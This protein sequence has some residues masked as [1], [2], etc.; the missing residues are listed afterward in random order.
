MRLVDLISPASQF[1]TLVK[2][3]LDEVITKHQDVLGIFHNFQ[4]NSQGQMLRPSLIYFTAGL[5][6]ENAECNLK[7]ITW[8]TCIELIHNASLLHDNVLDKQLERRGKDSFYKIFGDTP[9]ILFGNILYI[10]SFEKAFRS[11]DSEQLLALTNTARNMCIGELI[12]W[13][14]KD[15]QVTIKTYLKILHYKTGMLI[16]SSVE[17]TVKLCK[18]P[19]YAPNIKEI[20]YDLGVLYQLYDD[21]KDKDGKIPVSIIQ[22]LAKKKI[23]KLKNKLSFFSSKESLKYFTQLIH[24]FES[25]M[26]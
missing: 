23:L 9:S 11:L 16:Q 2:M 7:L 13:H 14:A 12:Q 5:L 22:R 21:F 4:K 18:H 17:Q 26:L 10:Y 1:Q 3:E 25:E 6:N 8:A 24:F 15:D 20:G 19:E